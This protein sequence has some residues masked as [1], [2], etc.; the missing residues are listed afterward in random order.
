VPRLSHAAHAPQEI[1]MNPQDS[2]FTH[3]YFHIPNLIMAAMIYTLIGRYILELI[4]AKRPDVV[5]M[6]VFRQITDPVL[7]AVRAITPAVV[8]NG[9]VLVFAIVWLISLRMFWLLTVLAAGVRMN[10]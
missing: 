2:F 5:I 4:F 10:T 9:L 3:W 1:A 6:R 7:G 8:P